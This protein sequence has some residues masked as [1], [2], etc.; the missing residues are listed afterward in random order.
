[1]PRLSV[2]IA[3]GENKNI[4]LCQGCAYECTVTDITGCKEFKHLDPKAVGEA[5]D[6]YDSVGDGA[7]HPSYEEMGYHCNLCGKKLNDE[8]DW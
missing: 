7:E 6:D 3:E 8:E 4:D 5:L 1:M 2:R